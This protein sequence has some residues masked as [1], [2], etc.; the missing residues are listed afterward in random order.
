MVAG[1]RKVTA[2][3]CVWPVTAVRPCALDRDITQTGS[4]KFDHENAGDANSQLK[5]NKTCGLSGHPEDARLDQVN[6]S[7][8]GRL[9][10]PAPSSEKKG[11]DGHAYA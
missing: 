4:F 6:K 2:G 5:W 3:V 10:R 11:M 9:S 1:Q 8:R 7:V